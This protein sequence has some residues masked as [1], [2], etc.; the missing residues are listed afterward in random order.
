MVYPVRRE[1]K[2]IQREL[3]TLWEYDGESL[4]HHLYLLT[5]LRPQASCL[6]SPTALRT[7][8]THLHEQN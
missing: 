3:D 1:R 4:L 2:Y 7:S 6:F 8:T 5:T